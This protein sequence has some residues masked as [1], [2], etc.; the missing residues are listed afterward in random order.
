M[1]TIVIE[2]KHQEN[3]ALS[4][5]DKPIWRYPETV[6]FIIPLE[7]TD[8]NLD[9]DKVEFILKEIVKQYND[10]YNK[11]DYVKHTI[12]DDNNILIKGSVLFNRLPWNERLFKK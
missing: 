11:Y 4:E 8:L 12:E 6:K 3:Y 2:T 1:R 9:T 7:E 10:M 5:R